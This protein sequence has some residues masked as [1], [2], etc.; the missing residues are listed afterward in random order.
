MRVC[1]TVK[2]FVWLALRDYQSVCEACACVRAPAM[3][4]PRV[5]LGPARCV[6]ACAMWCCAG[7]CIRLHLLAVHAYVACV[8]PACVCN[9][10]LCRDCLAKRAVAV[11]ARAVICACGPV[12]VHPHACDVPR[13]VRVVVRLQCSIR[14]S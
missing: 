2:L 12:R 11:C 7:S 5:C 6:A 10:S 14:M 3:V 8:S 9:S 1:V 13:A 4:R